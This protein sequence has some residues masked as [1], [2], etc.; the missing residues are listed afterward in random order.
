MTIKRASCGDLQRPGEEKDA[1]RPAAQ[2]RI[3]YI[4][5][6]NPALQGQGHHPDLLT[7]HVRVHVADSARI[8]IM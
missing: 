3:T 2:E 7:Q 5:P 8:Q 4:T 6:D 1:A